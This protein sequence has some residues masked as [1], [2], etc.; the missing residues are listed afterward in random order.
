ME[1]RFLIWIYKEA[2]PNKSWFFFAS[3][4]FVLLCASTRNKNNLSWNFHELWEIP[5]LPINILSYL[6][7]HSKVCVCVCCGLI[8]LWKWFLVILLWQI[9]F[10]MVFHLNYCF[11]GRIF[12]TACVCFE[13]VPLTWSGVE[14]EYKICAFICE[15]DSN[16]SSGWDY[17]LHVTHGRSTFRSL[18]ASKLVRTTTKIWR[19]TFFVKQMSG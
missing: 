6:F 12:F 18:R 2:I 4:G 16:H 17:I 1:N 19:T 7:C 3:T 8:I 14:I 15:F 9:L 11:W 13:C 10:S 5:R